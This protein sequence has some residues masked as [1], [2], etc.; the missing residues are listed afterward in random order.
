M[1]FEEKDVYAALGMEVPAKQPEAADPA[2]SQG[3]NDPSLAG[4]DGREDQATETNDTTPHPSPAATPALEDA[5]Y[6]STA[7]ATARKSSTG[8]RPVES[9][10]GE[11]FET[12]DG[13]EGERIAAGPEGPRNDNTGTGEQTQAD[14]KGIMSRAERAEQARLRREREQKAAVDAAVRAALQ[15]EREKN[16]ANLK[17]MFESAGMVDRYHDNKPITSLEEFNAFQAARQA[18]KLNRELQAG[19][20]TPESFQAAVD[21]SPA[22]REAR[23]AVERLKAREQAETEAARKAEFD[24][25][26]K[27]ELAEIHRMDPTVNS[28]E[29]ILAK[30]TGGEFARLVRENGLSFIQAYRLANADSIAEAKARAAREG[31]ARNAAGKGHLRSITSPAGGVLADVPAE[32]RRIYKDLF[33]DMTDEQ[34]RRDYARRMK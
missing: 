11:G 20:L 12:E 22:V 14:G 27:D 29:D 1:A 19:R 9:P 3:E 4:T 18:D 31:A 33:P 7:A 32:T 15:A 24:A 25:R 8:R 30:D 13:E 10:Q 17:A 2:A 5:S 21:N 16:S 34:I 28:V 26:V 6:G 23:E